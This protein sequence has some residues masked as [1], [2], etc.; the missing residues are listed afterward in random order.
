MRR[1]SF[2]W[3]SVVA[4]VAAGCGGA[5][6]DA[7]TG[8]AGT[9][10]NADQL[11]S[12]DAVQGPNGYVS[13]FGGSMYH[14]HAA[15]GFRDTPLPSTCTTRAT[16]GACT[17]F[18]GCPAFDPPAASSPQAGRLHLSL[19]TA[20]VDIDPQANGSYNEWSSDAA[21]PF[22]PGDVLSVAA[23]GGD[24]PAFN[25]SV[26]NPTPVHV[27][28]WG[29]GE[30]IDRHSPY[31]VHW[32]GASPGWVSVALRWGNISGEIRCSARASAGELVVP[33]EALSMAPAATVEIDLVGVNVTTVSAGK[34]TVQ[35]S[36]TT[37]GQGPQ[38]DTF[39]AFVV[40]Q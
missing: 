37:P 40:L 29:Q 11:P 28:H 14:G 24:V 35:M 3:A 5:T 30:A 20:T 19:G 17:V 26:V 21:A 16:F 36:A 12:L 1:R 38:F 7:G 6:H 18:V 34:Y 15:A 27:D 22:G 4:S 10:A 2:V 32:T 33:P 9:S 23:A 39:G 31:V 8:D 25:A 13:M